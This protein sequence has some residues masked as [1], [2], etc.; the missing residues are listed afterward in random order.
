[1]IIDKI[2]NVR[3]GDVV[4]YHIKHEETGGYLVRD[5]K[6][7]AYVDGDGDLMVATTVIK[8]LSGEIG[9]NWAGD[10]YL[11]F[12]SAEREVKL[13]T[14]IGAIVRADGYLHTK[15]NQDE[16]NSWIDSLGVTTND[17][18]LIE[19]GFEVIS[20]GVDID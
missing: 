8:Y 7:I 17:S 3:A 14:K 18:W 16:K 20:E 6:N 13:P 9:H 15:F 19:Q 2:E 10:D 5:Q 12:V 1:M 11:E 4:T